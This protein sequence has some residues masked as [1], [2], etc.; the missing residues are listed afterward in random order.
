M[1]ALATLVLGLG[2]GVLSARGM[3]P[4]FVLPL[5]FNPLPHLRRPYGMAPAAFAAYTRSC[6]DAE[7][8]PYRIGQTIGD[9][10]LSAGYHKRDGVLK[11]D[12]QSLDYTAAIDLAVFDLDRP[13]IHRFLHALTRR[14]YACWYREKG[15]WRGH[16]H[17]HAIYAA[18]PMKKQ[19]RGQVR[20][21]VRDRRSDGVK[22]LRW[23]RAWL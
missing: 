14:G 1:A 7:I 16:E 15:H 20:E 23:E 22:P 9:A 8:H 12:G 18:L 17:I 6:K 10:K 21:F 19:L 3:T 4:G 2:I 13:S 11:I 5:D